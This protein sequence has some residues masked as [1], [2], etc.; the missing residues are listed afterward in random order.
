VSYCGACTHYSHGLCGGLGNWIIVQ[1][2]SSDSL[3]KLIG[4]L[5]IHHMQTGGSSQLLLSHEI[6]NKR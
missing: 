2:N 5:V 1:L 4:G 3:E 6:N